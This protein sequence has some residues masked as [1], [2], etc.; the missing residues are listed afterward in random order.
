MNKQETL[1]ETYNKWSLE[2]AQKFA[3]SKFKYSDYSEK[4]YITIELILEVLKVGVLTGHKFGAK[5]QAK[6]MYSEKEVRNIAEEV[7][8]QAIG[9]PLEFTK[10]FEKWFEQFKKKV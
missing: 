2:E 4:G 6:R 5:W 7:R 8:W 9:N 3:L 10:N 1:E